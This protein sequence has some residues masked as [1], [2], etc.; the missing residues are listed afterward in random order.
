MKKILVL[1]LLLA[2]QAAWAWPGS[3]TSGD[4][5]QIA[6]V[7]DWNT[8]VANVNNGTTYSGQYF[9]LT[10]DISVTTMIGGSEGHEFSGTFDGDG[11]KL[12][13]SISDNTTQFVAPFHRV[14]GG[15]IKNLYVDGT[16]SSNQYHM[17]GLIGR[18]TGTI[19]IS[20]CVVAVDIRMSSDY[21]GGFVGNVGSRQYGGE[22]FVT[23]TGCLFIGTFTGVGGTRNK[24]AGFCG[25]G[26]STP[27][28]INCLENGTF[29][30]IGDFQPYL[31]QGTE[32][33]NPTS[34]SNS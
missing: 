20:N 31:Y 2:S 12:T 25:W 29:N 19:N 5:Y 28:F 4:P 8:L 17:S 33:Y 24:A 32:G 27:A 13:V 11:H 10:A 14:S 6:S 1:L 26:L 7:D 16:V 9:C 34:S 23:L 30:T 21:A 18:A 3:G 15:S 22:S